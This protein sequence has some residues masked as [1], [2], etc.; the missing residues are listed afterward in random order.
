[1]K[2]TLT[3]SL[4]HIGKPLA[5]ELIGKGHTVTIV[6]SSDNKKAEIERLGAKAAIGSM[7]D[8]GF[9]TKSFEGADLVYT[10]VPP[11]NYFDPTVDVFQR[12]NELGN[13]YAHAIKASGVKRVINLSTFGGDLE[14]GAGMLRG[15]H[16]VEGILNALPQDVS[17]THIRPTAFFYNLKHYIPTIKKAGAIIANYGADH[18]IPW[19]SPVDIAATIAA[20]IQTLF[21]GRK[22]VYVASEEVTGHETARI[23]G[24]AIGMPELKWILISDAENLDALKKVGMNPDI[25]EGMIEMYHSL[26]NGVLAG[27]YNLNR[28]VLGKVKLVDYAKEFAAD[29]NH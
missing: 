4:G 17:I 19:V 24:E 21:T 28:P 18:I 1:M 2:I 27:H 23:L 13:N 11:F 3:G 12:Y 15:A 25:A 9:I 26:Q 14:E 6:S 22:A 8:R 10:M 7:F 29:F 5:K 20:E 16:D